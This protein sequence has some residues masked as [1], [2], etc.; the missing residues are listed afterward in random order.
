MLS[1]SVV[2]AH[3]RLA[4]GKGCWG[5]E[6]D[7]LSVSVVP[8]NT[9]ARK[10]LELLSSKLQSGSAA[11][12]QGLPTQLGS[13]EPMMTDQA[14]VLQR[15]QPS[16]LLSAQVLKCCTTCWRKEQRGDM[17]LQAVNPAGTACISEP[18]RRHAYQLP[19]QNC[20]Y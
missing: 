16:L 10:S 11:R 5:R 14:I 18:G 3:T 1:S 2:Q 20:M 17:T 19:L 8:C 4:A 6:T 12:L 15:G 9:A 7:C 13:I